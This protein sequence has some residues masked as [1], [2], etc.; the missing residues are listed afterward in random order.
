[1]PHSNSAESSQFTLTLPVGRSLIQFIQDRGMPDE[2]LNDDDWLMARNVE[3]ACQ[4][5]AETMNG[6]VNGIAINVKSLSEREFS[7]LISFLSEHDTGKEGD[8]FRRELVMLRLLFTKNLEEMTVIA[9]QREKKMQKK[10]ESVVEMTISACSDLFRKIA[11]ELP[12]DWRPSAQFN[13]VSE[14]RQ[15]NRPGLLASSSGNSPPSKIF[16]NMRDH[17]RPGNK[18][19]RQRYLDN[20]GMD[21]HGVVGGFVTKIWE[22][23]IVAATCYEMSLAAQNAFISQT[24]NSVKGKAGRGTLLFFYAHARQSLCNPTL[25]DKNIAI[26]RPVPLQMM[27]EPNSFH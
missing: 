8:R 13:W 26:G 5:A 3:L 11:P 4:Q 17:L 23:H 18:V 24:S 21:E 12:A 15:S 16:L 6:Q 1:M 7:F 20:L 9:Q 10:A 2:G 22:L 14:P 19:I 27:D 25:Q